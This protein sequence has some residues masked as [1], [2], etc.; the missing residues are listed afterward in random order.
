MN[1]ARKVAKN[2]F[3]NFAGEIIARI[4]TFFITL[5]LI[6]YLGS[7][8]FGKYSLVYAFLSFFQIFMSMGIDYIIVRELSRDSRK[9]AELIGNA[10]SLIFFSSFIGL[11]L[12]WIILRWMHYPADIRWLIYLASLSMLFSSGALFNNIFQAKLLMKYL[13]IITI[14]MKALL[15]IFTMVL[16][17]LKADLFHFILINLLIN[18]T[19]IILICYQAR[20][21]LPIKIAVDFKIWK[22]L[23]KNFWPL[24][25]S[26]V[27]ISIYTRIDEVMLFHMRG[28]EELGFY[29]AS[30]KL[31]ELPH[32]IL[33]VFMASVFPLLSEYAKTAQ[34]AF[35]KTCELSFK[36][37][38][39]FIM[40]VAMATVV[41]RKQIILACYG[42]GFLPSQI[43]LAIL[44]CSTV[45]TYAI[46][47][48][49]LILI[50]ANLQYL[51]IIF[52]GSF[53]I[54]TVFLN[55]ILIPKYGFL[56]AAVATAISYGFIIPLSYALKR[57]RRFAQSMV[58]SMIRPFLAAL[59][60]VYLVYCLSSLYFI[61]NLVISGFIYIFLMLFIGA[62][63]S[64]DVRYAKG[65]LI[66][67]TV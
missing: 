24:A 48:H 32:V 50:A 15:G 28:K 36:Y 18:I 3:F 53:V 49:S 42:Q 55:S 63:N 14:T 12:C 56:G 51:D 29:A 22:E 66:K 57:T 33:G 2:S 31:A 40:P 10:A 17:L 35:K 47:T 6:R 9:G 37:P 11:I 64:E 23:L 61:F 20:K 25:V 52:T 54:L 65:I 7:G 16:I 59:F 46:T 45:F 27:F 43:A 19:Q 67:S 8:D 5:I 21:L 4:I 39:I 1:T 26:T 62:I 58:K 34:D 38:M 30:V 60:A 41:Y 44:M 13:A